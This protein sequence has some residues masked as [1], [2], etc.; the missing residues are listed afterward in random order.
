MKNTRKLTTEEFDAVAETGRSLLPHLR[1]KTAR[2]VNR[3]GIREGAG[4]KPSG[5]SGRTVRSKEAVWKTLDAEA[6]QAGLSVSA[7]IERRVTHF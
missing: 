3:G 2:R 5:R 6:A 1:I 7:I 4:R